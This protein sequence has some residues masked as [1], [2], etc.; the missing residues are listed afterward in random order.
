M[1]Q[2]TLQT[3][4]VL[5]TNL[6]GWRHTEP[7]TQEAF[8]AARD[9]TDRL[10]AC[11]AVEEAFA[12]LI[13]NYVSFEKAIAGANIENMVECGVS[14][15]ALHNR[16][17]EVD[18]HLV[19]LLAAGQMFTDHVCGRT[20]RHFGRTSLEADNLS[21]A[22]QE[23][24]DR[25]LGFWATECLRD[26]VL[27]YDLPITSWTTGGRWVGLDETNGQSGKQNASA[28]LEHSVSFSFDPGMLGRN[29]KVDPV[30]IDRLAGRRDA[31][32]NVSWVP[33]IREYVEGLSL[34]LTDVRS[35]WGALE[36]AASVLLSDMTN[37]Y[38]STLPAGAKQPLYVFIVEMDES[39]RW[40]RD[41]VLNRGLEIQL[42]EL[43]SQH[44]PMVNLHR[45]S[46]VG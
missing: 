9:A 41:V 29:R 28:K 12:V 43:R 4:F 45:R 27:H 25:L 32:G 24:R 3:T 44:R 42:S 34:V 13:A 21:A 33:V 16:R 40:L 46:L 2:H 20:R 14:E 35:L 1:E 6:L 8:Q 5:T 30:L 31:K 18:R 37:A 19:N 36:E 7:S 15:A 26:A 38:R 39:R 11:L 10:M 23:K 22:F 17:R